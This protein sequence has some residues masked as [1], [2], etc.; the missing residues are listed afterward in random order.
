M[1]TLI[2]FAATGLFAAGAAAG[3]IGMVT[4][5]IRREEKNPV[6]AVTCAMIWP[7]AVSFPGPGHGIGYVMCMQPAAWPEPD[8]QIAAIAAMY[9]VRKTARPLPV[10]P[11]PDRSGGLAWHRAARHSRCRDDFRSARRSQR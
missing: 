8:P 2:P 11:A 4:V 7:A 10:L 1:S 5:A 6:R 9:G 3:I